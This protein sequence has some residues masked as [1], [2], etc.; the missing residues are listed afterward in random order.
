M[1]SPRWFC[2]LC[3][4]LA[5]C[6]VL[7]VVVYRK[8]PEVE[9]HAATRAPVEKDGMSE[10]VSVHE[11]CDIHC[12]KSDCCNALGDYLKP[13]V[14]AQQAKRRLCDKEIC[15]QVLL[16]IV[17]NSPLYEHVPF[18]RKMY[19]E[20][21]AKV[22]FYGP[23]SNS[24]QGVVGCSRHDNENSFMA[25]S[26][27]HNTVAQAIIENPGYDGYLWMSDD[28]YVNYNII[29]SRYN[30]L[31]VWMCQPDRPFVPM[32]KTNEAWFWEKTACLPKLRAISD[33]LP[34]RF[35][36]RSQT[37]YKCEHCVTSMTADWGYVPARYVNRF[38]FLTYI[39]RDVFMEISVPTVLS[40][41]PNSRDEI[42]HLSET[43][44]LFGQDRSKEKDLLDPLRRQPTLMLYHPL[45]LHK[46]KQLQDRLW[47]EWQ[48]KLKKLR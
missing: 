39:L 26:F 4:G 33:C 18:L 37:W 9:S 5:I 41:L 12:R 19:G 36:S 15:L 27:F 47:E 46:N 11:L 23:K 14:P 40:L 3:V 8:G 21:F 29:F 2:H 45:K 42:E 25:G 34:E 10:T 44:E 17:F 22:V 28:D 16:I 1:C 30:P 32:L 6:V 38:V 48:T 7:F 13:T 43:L 35:F 20:S 24:S 31:K